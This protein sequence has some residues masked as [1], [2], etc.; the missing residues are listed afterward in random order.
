MTETLELRNL[1][2]GK[3]KK[4]DISDEITDVLDNWKNKFIQQMGREPN[5]VDLFY[6]GYVLSNPM[7]REKYRVKKIKEK[8]L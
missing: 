7:V 8:E 1:A 2:E 6:A 4:I 3:I 5:E